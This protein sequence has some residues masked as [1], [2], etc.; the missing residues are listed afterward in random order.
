MIGIFHEMIRYAVHVKEI[1]CCDCYFD[2]IY[3]FSPKK[4]NFSKKNFQKNK[5][6]ILIL[7]LLHLYLLVMIF[8]DFQKKI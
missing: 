3:F 8:S 7:F 4:L 6:V 5:I 2:E 1:F